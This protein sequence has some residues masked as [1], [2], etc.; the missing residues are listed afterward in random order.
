MGDFANLNEEILLVLLARLLIIRSAQDIASAV[1]GGHWLAWE[2]LVD[3]GEYVS[4]LFPE[5]VFPDIE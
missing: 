3:R 5:G 1:L 2:D 4:Q